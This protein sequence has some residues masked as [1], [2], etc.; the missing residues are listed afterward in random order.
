V[1][2]SWIADRRILVT[3]IAGDAERWA[4]RLRQLGA[5]PIVMPCVEIAP[6]T[7]L[8]VAGAL[9]TALAEASWLAV[10]SRRA[11]E[12]V[13]RITGRTLPHRLHVAAVGPETA[14]AAAELIGRVDLV[15]SPSSA[16]GLANSLVARI[17]SAKLATQVVVAG[18]THGRTDV[19]CLL[20][21]AGVSVRRVN[22]YAIVPVPA[23]ESKCDLSNDRID[24]I[25]LASPSAAQ[26]LVN[27]ARRPVN[28]LVIT[29]GPT[30]SAAAAAL[31]L[32]VSA[33][34]SRPGLD[35]MLEAYQA[36]EAML[37]RR[38]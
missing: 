22:V 12:A 2:A 24:A 29:I 18:A 11:V 21:D 9:G 16:R 37:G 31:A 19:E 30:T 36:Q 3:R 13:V 6:L 33:E 34:A 5:Q 4:E 17:G 20:E 32:P 15:A 7:D 25:L 23:V 14:R 35:G 38:L 1:I 26:G 27:R 28:A 10:A 8:E